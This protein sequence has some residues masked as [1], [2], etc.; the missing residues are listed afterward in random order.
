MKRATPRNGALN[1]LPSKDRDYQTM[2]WLDCTSEKD[3]GKKVVNQL[4]CKV[5]SDFAERI[6]GSKNFSDKWIIG[7]DSVRLS[8]VCDHAQ[9]DQHAHAMLLLKK[10]HAKSAGLP[11]SSY[12]PI[13]QA[14]NKLSD[15]ERVKLQ[16]KFDIAHFVATQKLPFTMYPQI[17]ELE[18]HHG[19]SLGTSYINETAG[20]E[21]MHYIAESRRQELKQTLAKSK[22]FSLLLDGSTDTANIDNELILAV[23]CDRDGS[24]EKIHTRMEYFTVVRPQSVTAKGLFN[25]LETALQG[26]GIKEISAEKCLK[27]VGIGTDGASANIAASWLKGLVESRLCWVFGCGA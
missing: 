5:C 12:D 11:P 15:D 25:V 21:M 14:L 7:A 16:L 18:V 17:C 9:S 1:T 23:W 20:K 6:R 3:G 27:L 26:L 2:S 22:F 13:A 4:K 8:N 24:D 19:V 10:Q